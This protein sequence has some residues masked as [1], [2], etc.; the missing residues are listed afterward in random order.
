MRSYL[1]G[2]AIVIILSTSIKNIANNSFKTTSN[3]YG[4][5]NNKETYITSNN[6]EKDDIVD[7]VTDD[8]FYTFDNINHSIKIEVIED[9]I[10]RESAKIKITDTDD[11]KYLWSN[12]Y[13]LLKKENNEWTKVEIKNLV[14][15]SLNMY[16][17]DDNNELEMVVNYGMPYGPL[18][19]GL[20]IIVKPVSVNYNELVDIYSNEFEIK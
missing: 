9:S 14:G 11:N 1:L 12:Q 13:H 6:L 20:Y 8:S 16:T 18:E 2:I 19:D 15:I 4:E 3:E 7:D 5:K 10:T 17:T